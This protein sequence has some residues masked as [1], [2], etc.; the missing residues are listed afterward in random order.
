MLTLTP[1]RSDS[2]VWTV[3]LVQSGVARQ[4][5]SNHARTS[6]RSAASVALTPV[7]QGGFGISLEP[8]VQAIDGGTMQGHRGC[9]QKI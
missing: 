6:P 3:R 7:V 9:A 5:A 8:L 4:K 2:A 1:K